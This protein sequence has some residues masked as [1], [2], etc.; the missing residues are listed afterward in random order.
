M[1]GKV[2][3]IFVA[4]RRLQV[5]S[6]CGFLKA[7]ANLAFGDRSAEWL[8]DFETRASNNDMQNSASHNNTHDNGLLLGSVLITEATM[9]HDHE[10]HQV[11]MRKSR[12]GVSHALTCYSNEVFNN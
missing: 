8:T 7:S 9:M 2:L 4:L 6:K 10:R 3:P 12:A 1:S 5:L 11:M